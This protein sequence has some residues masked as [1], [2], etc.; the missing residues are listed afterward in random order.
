MLDA[1][2]TLLVFE[3]DGRLLMVASAK[4]LTITVLRP[5]AAQGLAFADASASYRKPRGHWY[6][7]T[8]VMQVNTGRSRNLAMMVME[9]VG[10]V[11]RTRSCAK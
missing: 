6:V 2:E 10:R 9:E 4:T 5:G 1:A 11:L 7:R 8:L 3:D